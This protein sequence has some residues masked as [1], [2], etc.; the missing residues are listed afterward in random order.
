V[1]LKKKLT[2]VREIEG[3]NDRELYSYSLLM[4]YNTSDCDNSSIVR[5]VMPIEHYVLLKREKRIIALM[6]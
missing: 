4:L 1:Q 3:K 2:R 5:D 6:H